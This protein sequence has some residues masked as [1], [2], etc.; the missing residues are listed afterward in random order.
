MQVCKRVVRYGNCLSVRHSGGPT[1]LFS[2]AASSVIL[3]VLKPDVDEKGVTL[4]N[5]HS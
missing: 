1:N 3:N 4:V 5:D 2:T